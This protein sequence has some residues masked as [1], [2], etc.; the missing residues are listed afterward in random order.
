MRDLLILGIVFGALPF[1]LRHTWIGVMLWTW[2]SIMNPHRLAFGFAHD[3]PLAAVAAGSVLVSLVLTRDKLRMPWT[4]PVVVLFLFVGWMCLTTVFA[5]DPAGSWQQLDKVLKIQ[6]MTAIALLALQERRHIEVFI[7]VN[8]LSLAFFGVKGGLHTII[9]GGVSTVWG[10]AGSFIEDNNHLAV[11]LIMAIPLLNFLRMIATRRAVRLGLLAVMVLTAVSAIG[12]QS[13][14]GLLAIVAMSIVLWYRSKRKLFFGV[15]MAIVAVGIVSFMPDSWD[16]RMSTIGEYAEDRSAMGRIHAWLFCF[17]LANHNLT[18][19]GFN[20]YNP[21]LFTIYAPPE[22]VGFRV[23]H[24]IYFSVLGEHGYIGLF[25]FGLIWWL[26]F[27]VSGR[28][29]HEARKR[30]E[31]EWAYDLAGMCQVSLVGYMVGGAFLQ[32]AYFDLPYNI[33]VILVVTQRW[34]SEYSEKSD[35]SGAFAR[36]NPIQPL[37]SVTA[38]QDALK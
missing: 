36:A 37:G 27:R 13:R 28:V 11:A 25:L 16:S 14:G 12:S 1:A 2:I 31:T 9:N 33:L 10:P 6:L 17:N 38:T 4:P 21:G 19:G 7:W 18:G 26:L 35:N 23:A 15:V 34:L 5:F 22:A 8:A 3:A 20:I 30:S 29:R 32:L 24:S